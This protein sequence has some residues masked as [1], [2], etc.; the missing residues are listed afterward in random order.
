MDQTG[1]VGR[2]SMDQTGQ[3]SVLKL[4][5][6]LNFFEFLKKYNCMQLSSHLHFLQTGK[7]TVCMRVCIEI[8]CESM[9]DPNKPNKVKYTDAQWAKDNN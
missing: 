8:L 6:V 7:A 3:V 1:P 2:P 4:F 5:A 9:T